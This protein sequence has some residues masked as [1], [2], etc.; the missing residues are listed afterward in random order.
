MCFE[1]QNVP[2]AK[3]KKIPLSASREQRDIHCKAGVRSD[4]HTALFGLKGQLVAEVGM[5]DGD[6]LAGTL[7]EAA[8]A[9][10]RHAVLG[11][12]S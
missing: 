5:R 3:D 8:A 9:Q 1:I 10:V 11:C 6:E 7:T 12:S 4:H 2:T